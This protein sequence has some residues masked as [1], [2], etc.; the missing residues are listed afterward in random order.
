MIQHSSPVSPPLTPRRAFRDLGS[1]I[2]GGVASGVAAHLGVPVLWVRVFFV[3]TAL[4]GGFGLLLYAG[5]WMF[6]PASQRF[7][8]SAPGLESATRTGKRPG[9]RSRFRDAG[10]A[11]ALG[12]LLFGVVLGFEG[13]FGQGALFWP[14]VLGVSGIGLL[15]RGLRRRGG[16]LLAAELAFIERAEA[17]GSFR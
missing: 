12:A 6:V 2:A 7:E 13:I 8:V 11:V 10:P 1:A 14:V 5:L 9:R 16:A 4:L 15:W 3:S 17:R